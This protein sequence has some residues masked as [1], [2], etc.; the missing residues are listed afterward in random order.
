[1]Q[2]KNREGQFVK[3]DEDSFK[4]AAANAH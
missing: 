4:A 1:V 3:P 2:L